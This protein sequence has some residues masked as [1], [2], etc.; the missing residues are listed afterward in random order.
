MKIISSTVEEFGPW[1]S[2]T[3]DWGSEDGLII[4]IAENGAG[5]TFMLEAIFAALF[6]I[7]PSYKGTIFEAVR[8][9]GTGK[10]MVEAVFEYESKRYRVTRTVKVTAK[11]RGQ[12]AVICLDGIDEPLAGPKMRDFDEFIRNLIGDADLALATWFSCYRSIGDICELKPAA[13]S[14]LISEFIQ[15]ADLGNIATRAKASRIK[16][17]T[18]M[19]IHQQRVRDFQGVE[20]PAGSIAAESELTFLETAIAAEE[21]T[22]K[23]V[24]EDMTRMT[25][26]V[27]KAHAAE[28]Y[29]RDLALRK[30]NVDKLGFEISQLAERIEKKDDLVESVGILTEEKATYNR[31]QEAIRYRAQTARL[32]EAAAVAEAAIEATDLQLKRRRTVAAKVAKEHADK[33]PYTDIR[34][35][36]IK[37]L[38]T[39]KE[40]ATLLGLAEIQLAQVNQMT[41]R[42]DATIK[43]LLEAEMAV[44]KM[45]AEP[46]ELFDFET[47]LR[48]HRELSQ[49]QVRLSTLLQDLNTQRRAASNT[50]AHASTRLAVWTQT[51]EEIDAVIKKI[52]KLSDRTTLLEIIEKAFGRSGVQALL[53]EHAIKPFEAMASEM[54]QAATDGQND[55]RIETMKEN[56]DGTIAEQVSILIADKAGERDIYQYSGGERR[57]LSTIIRLALARWIALRSGRQYGTIMIDEAFDSLDPNHVELLIEMLGNVTQYFENIILVTPNPAYTAR[58]SN[59]ITL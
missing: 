36:E 54:M 24:T 35:E 18:E 45:E 16:T 30:E 43:I 34:K 15:T 55:V 58:I 22:L 4:L 27:E 38:D 50:I 39:Y 42:H 8:Q 6:G 10:A 2:R 37:L 41:V 3:I 7:W 5:K 51:K 49:N 40:A 33:N 46:P 21:T 14:D 53:I 29:R 25:D 1:V 23:D 19:D 28:N 31:I 32:E 9:N 12:D 11:T 13:R 57:M 52:S 47:V 56:R 20:Q 48:E 26:R 44:E 59:R 17:A